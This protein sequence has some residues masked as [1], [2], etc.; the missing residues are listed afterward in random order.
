[1]LSVSAGGK[2]ASL[3]ARDVRVRLCDVSGISREQATPS[4]TACS[5]RGWPEVIEGFEENARRADMVDHLG[6]G[7]TTCIAP[8]L[9]CAARSDLRNA[10]TCR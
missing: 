6:V 5:S 2:S 3:A 7:L 4:T 9:I 1:V 8:E 10:H